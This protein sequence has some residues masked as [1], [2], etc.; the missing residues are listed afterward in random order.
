M[1]MT[2]NLG[3]RQFPTLRKHL[4]DKSKFVLVFCQVPLHDGLQ[5]IVDVTPRVL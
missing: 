1:I 5:G 4:H 3:Q 2:L